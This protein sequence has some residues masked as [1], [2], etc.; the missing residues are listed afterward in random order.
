MN[1]KAQLDYPII[2][3]IVIVFGLLIIA[4]VMMKVM[5]SVQNGMDAALG[6]MT[7]GSGG[8]EA[9]AGFNTV[10]NTA[11]TFWDKLII[12]AFFLAILMLFISAFLIDSSPFWVIL[13]IFISL[14]VILFAP[15]IIGALDAVYDSANFAQEVSNLAFLDAVRRHFG[16]FLV[17]IM[18]MT[19]I[20]IYGKVALL[21][22]GGGVRS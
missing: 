12:A 18:V 10:M 20:I 19:G 17:G 5:F 4:P 22:K 8:T 2:P 1:K 7:E 11:I 6:N 13:Y 16:E 14:M 3:F 15:N 9:Q 21:G